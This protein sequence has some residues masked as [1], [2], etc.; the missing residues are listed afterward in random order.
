V[1]EH[2]WPGWPDDADGPGPDPHELHHPDPDDVLGL[3]DLVPVPT[4]GTDVDDAAPWDVP[5]VFGDVDDDDP[6]PALTGGFADTTV[7]DAAD[8]GV[9][10]YPD[11]VQLGHDGLIGPVGADPDAVV[12]GDAGAELFPPAVDVGELPEPVDG[13][14]WIDTGSLGVVPAGAVAGTEPVDSAGLAAYAQVDV[15]PGVDPWAAL[16]ASDDPATS[17]LARFWAPE[18]PTD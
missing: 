15:A 13:F 9:D 18:P 3:D 16:A 1:N 7:D 2:G 11:G 8:D 6:G 5:V 14:P 4:G 12:E 17:A 10:P